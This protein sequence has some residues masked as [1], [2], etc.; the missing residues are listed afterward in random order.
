MLMSALNDLVG[1]PNREKEVRAAVTPIVVY[2]ADKQGKPFDFNK[3][4]IADL[5]VKTNEGH[6]PLFG[7]RNGSYLTALEM[8][9]IPEF[10]S[11]AARGSIDDAVIAAEKLYK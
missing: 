10:S 6:Y 8:K 4:G 11:N 3:D 9:K 2:T 5:C 7:Q 1:D